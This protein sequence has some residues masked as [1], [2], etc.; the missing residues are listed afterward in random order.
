[1]KWLCSLFGHRWLS[2]LWVLGENK[3]A[4]NSLAWTR[5][6][7]CLRCQDRLAQTV[8]AVCGKPLDIN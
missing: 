3:Q 8:P 4:N 2:T 6:R 5:E 1:M 7:R